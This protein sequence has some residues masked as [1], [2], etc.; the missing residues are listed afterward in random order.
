MKK[1]VLLIGWD[2]ADWKIIDKLF[3]EG[4]LPN[5]Q[6]LVK[7][8]VRT[9]LQTLDPPLSPMLW[10]SI[11]TGFRADI[12]G[13]GGFIEPSPDGNGIRPVTSTSRKVK[14]IWNILQQ[15]GLKSNVVAWWPSNPVEPISGVMVSNLFQ[16]ANKPLNE[17][18][19]FPSGTIHPPEMEDTLR[20]C[21]VHPHEITAQMLVPFVPNILQKKDLIKHLKIQGILKNIAQA[22]TVHA[23]STLIQSETDWDFMAVYHD[24]L[25]HFCHIGMR[26]HPP[27]RPEIDKEEFDD[28]QNIV[29]AGYRFHDL[30]LGRTLELVD[31]NTTIILISDHGFYSDHQRPI[32][33]PN[34]PSGPAVEHSPYGILVMAGPGI[35]KGEIVSRGSVLDITPTLL[36]YFGLPVG[37]DME[38]KVLYQLFEEPVIAQYVDSWQN[39]PGNTGEHDETKKEDPIAAQ[40]AMQQL[41]ELGY[42]DPPG[43]EISK[44]IEKVVN[45]SRYYV[46]RNQINGGR[47]EQ[48]I[49]TLKE[50]FE[51]TGFHRYGQRLATCYLN[52]RMYSECQTLIE[53]LKNNPQPKEESIKEAV[54]EN[55]EE[56]MYLEFLEGLYFLAT[57]QYRKAQPILEEIL[58]RYPNN[59]QVQ[60][61]IANILADRKRFAEAE[62]AFIKALAIDDQNI[63][64]HHGLGLALLRQE[65]YNEAL[66]EF[67]ICI[68]L[69]FNFV[70]AHYHLGET[71]FKLKAFQEA[72]QAFLVCLKLAP[73]MIKP[74]RWLTEIYKYHLVDQLKLEEHFNLI[75]KKIT[76]NI[77]IITGHF[78]A[79]YS[80][81]YALLEN[82][83]YTIIQV[84]NPTIL[85][86]QL[87]EMDP[88]KIAKTLFF[89]PFHLLSFLSNDL[90]FKMIQLEKSQAALIQEYSKKGLNMKKEESISKQALEKIEEEKYK[91]QL[92]LN[93]NPSIPILFIKEEETNPNYSIDLEKLADFLVL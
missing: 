22:A 56:P 72:E 81:V 28:F 34:E 54:N 45:E 82:E 15:N 83:N 71:L 32:Y 66:D 3:A 61:N 36:Y 73:N 91:F 65:N 63:H 87:A 50:I 84:T 27:F 5:L 75:N 25:D 37:K 4:K 2:A 38:G 40:E 78:Y 41:V 42:I 14:A 17:P 86:A 39:I 80:Q 8:G 31:E 60:L 55:A 48:A 52:K 11:A 93:A 1:K 68:D 67:L 44:Q 58:E 20:E 85:K 59:F 77:N 18:W 29:E 51:K 16:V 7:R 6:S 33:I 26:F 79:D 74:H 46:A 9:Q 62:E 47:F 69:N 53:Y 64:A 21:L 90:N 76:G 89:I 35:K 43:E 57:N 24:A 23:A 10:T 70:R 49:T 19:V 12:H 30:M 92:W 13:I 88:E